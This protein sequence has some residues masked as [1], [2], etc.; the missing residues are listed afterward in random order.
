M[1]EYFIAL[2]FCDKIKR[3][4]ESSQSP[5]ELYQT[6]SFDGQSCVL[7]EFTNLLG[8]QALSLFPDIQNY[9]LQMLRKMHWVMQS[10]G[11][12]FSHAF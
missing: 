1:H 9:L 11:N 10:G 5:Q 4:I 2:S 3:L 12:H 6:V 8:M 7:T